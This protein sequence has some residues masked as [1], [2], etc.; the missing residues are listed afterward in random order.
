MNVD[1]PVAAGPAVLADYHEG[2][3]GCP[4]VKSD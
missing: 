2:K 1:E 4:R 3:S